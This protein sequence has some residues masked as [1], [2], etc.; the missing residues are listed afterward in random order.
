MED[1]RLFKGNIAS[2]EREPGRPPPEEPY[3][4][5]DSRKK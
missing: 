1:G 4:R 2:D 3:V 5:S